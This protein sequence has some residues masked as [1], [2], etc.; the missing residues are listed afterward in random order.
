MRS[1]LIL[2]VVT[3]VWACN[4]PKEVADSN[5]EAA[6]TTSPD[7][8]VMVVEKPVEP[9][10]SLVISFSKTPCF[11]RCPVYKVKVYES[12]FATYEGLNFAEKLGLYSYRFSNEE[13]EA[14]RNVSY[15]ED[16]S[17]FH[18]RNYF[19]FMFNN[20]GMNFYDMAIARLNQFDGERFSYTRKK[21]E[22]EGDFFSIMGL[23]LL[24]LL[25]ELRS[26]GVL[27]S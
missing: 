1:L 21:T 7:T 4:G 16:S 24:P 11:G 2:F 18:V 10:D 19:L 8:I 25:K 22:S 23:P 26:L 27:E 9:I 13:I 17:K 3:F 5:S 12:G 20:M 6:A 14:I 15:P